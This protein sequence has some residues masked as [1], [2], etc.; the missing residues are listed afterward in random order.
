MCQYFHSLKELEILETFII[1]KLLLRNVTNSVCK[2]YK[3]IALLQTP[4][5]GANLKIMGVVNKTHPL[6]D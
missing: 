1:Y 3:Y 6:N 4:S 5:H 2:C